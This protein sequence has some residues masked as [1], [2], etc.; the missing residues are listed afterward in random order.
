MDTEDVAEGEYEEWIRGKIYTTEEMNACNTKGICRK[1]R[2]LYALI[3]NHTGMTMV[4]QL[5][6]LDICLASNPNLDARLPFG[7]TPLHV[8][9]SR[10][11]EGLSLI[12]GLCLAGAKLRIYDDNAR[13][14]QR[15]AFIMDNYVCQS[16]LALYAARDAQCTAAIIALLNRRFCK[17]TRMPLDVMRIICRILWAP[18]MRRR[19]MK[20]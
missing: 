17:A 15:L 12:H 3:V 16:V 7:Q 9:I 1:D 11:G 10:R 4:H 18:Q 13:S 2:L 8:A 5:R 19:E 6:L 20:I 14:P